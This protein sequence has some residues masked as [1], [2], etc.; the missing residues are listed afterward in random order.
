MTRDEIR[1]TVVRAVSEHGC[2]LGVAEITDET[3]MAQDA[4]IDGIDVYEFGWALKDAFGPVADSVP[5]ERFSDQRYSFYG[6]AVFGAPFWLLWRLLTYPMN[7]EFMP[8]PSNNS[9]RLT[10]RHLTDVLE[11]GEWFEP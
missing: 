11:R 4:K 7:R 3:A 8:R 9:E 10:V 2:H 5:W 6:C 1:A